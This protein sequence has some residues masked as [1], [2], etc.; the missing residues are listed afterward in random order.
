M[1]KLV[2]D[3]GLLFRKAWSVRLMLLAGT[4]SGCEMALPMFSDSIPRNV[5]LSLS[6]LVSIGA[7]VSRFVAQP[8]MRDGTQ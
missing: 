8:K 6:I 5:F 1:M 7:L 4:L 2:D 3:A